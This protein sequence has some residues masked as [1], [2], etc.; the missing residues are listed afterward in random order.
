VSFTWFGVRK[1]LTPAQRAE[2][3]ESFGAEGDFLSAGKK[4]IDTRHV[5]FR[6]VTAI[7]GRVLAYWR[8]RTLPFTEPGIR[9]LRQD[10]I[11]SFDQV[12]TDFRTELEDAVASL[13]EHYA[14]LKASAADRLGRL[15]SEADYP[16]SLRGWFQVSWDF[17]SIEPPNYLRQLSPRLFE[18]E[19]RRITSRF[20]EA[21]QLAEQAFAE[22]FGKL[23][24][25]LADRLSGTEGQKKIF[26]DSAVTNLVEFFERFRTLNIHSNEDLDALVQRAQRAV[27][28]IEP[29]HLRSDDRLRRNLAQSMSQIQSGLDQLL[30]DQPRRRILRGPRPQSVEA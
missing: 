16:A 27:Q 9:L 2:A 17:P 30:V 18:E 25:H 21:V 29:D 7:R 23:V 1:T 22:E 6:A 13:D 10:E 3:A 28:G 20:D 15:Y 11:E 4:L 14:E 12:M 5:A 24:S 8:G 19:C 26:R